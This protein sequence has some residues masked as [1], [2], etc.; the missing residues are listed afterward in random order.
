MSE[1]TPD[2]KKLEELLFTVIDHAVDSI[3]SSGGPL[4]PFSITEDHA[5]ERTLARYA[6]ERL[7]EGVV[8][9]QN[10]I[11]ESKD[12]ISRYAMAWDGRVTFEGRKWDA[13]IVEAGD[14]IGPSGL[15][16][17]QRYR[18]RRILKGIKPVGNPAHFDS[19]PSRIQ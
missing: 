10:S 16:V 11:K 17:W 13:V 2:Q 19:P 7:E 4:I 18:P 9:G 3:K 6:A 8:L 12:R 1:G 14:K 5:G 15:L